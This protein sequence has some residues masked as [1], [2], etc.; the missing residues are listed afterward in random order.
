MTSVPWLF[1]SLLTTTAPA[2]TVDETG[3]VDTSTA[4]ASVGVSA[5]ADAGLDDTSSDSSADWGADVE[6]EPASEPEPAPAAVAS[7]TTAAAAAAQ[8]SGNQI[9]P[10]KHRVGLGVIRTIAGVNGINVRYFATDKFM[11]GGS[12]GVAVFTYRE[13]DP[14]SVDVC[15][16]P[17]CELENIRSTAAIAGNFEALYFAALGRENGHL[18]FR[19]DFGLGGRFGVMSIVNTTDIENNLDDPLEFHV[20]VPLILQ[21]MF[22]NNFA[23]SPEFGVDFR[24]VPGSRA[25]GDSNPGLRAP[26]D[27]GV[28]GPGFGFD[29]T[30]GIG[31]FAGASMHYYF[32]K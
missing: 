5:D 1:A 31:L 17:N 24:F 30:P 29:I 19:A 2:D 25:D 12:V 13:N 9:S 28:A 16:G 7:T 3:P 26:P 32:G 4:D 23:L 18:P 11:I 27:G 22:G 20:E 15:P 10:F 8:P 14:T 21:L 6:P